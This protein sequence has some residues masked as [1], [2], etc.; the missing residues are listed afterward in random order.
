MQLQSPQT[1]D[2]EASFGEDEDPE[3]E[4]LFVCERCFS[5]KNYG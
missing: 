2:L 4:F 5:L 3:E 1:E